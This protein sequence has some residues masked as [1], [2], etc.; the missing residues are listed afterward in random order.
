MKRFI[1][2]G[3]GGLAVLLAAYV[4]LAGPERSAAPPKQPPPSVVQQ[5]QEKSKF[6]RV[7]YISEIQETRKQLNSSGHVITIHHN[8]N[9]TSHYMKH[10]VTVKF[11]TPPSPDNLANTM[12]RINGW[13]K[14]GNGTMYIFKSHTMSTD[15][16]IAYFSKRQDVQFA[17]PNFLLLPNTTPNDTLY[18]RYQWNMPAIDMERAWD[19]SKG[20][21]DVIIAIIDTGV[22]LTHPEFEGKL[23]SG[24]NVLNGSNKPQDDNGHGT[25]V[26]GIIA[27]KTNNQRGIAGIAWNNKIMPVKGIGA[28]GS[29][30]SFDIAQGVIWAADHGAKVINMSVGN[31]HP[32]N[33]LHDAIKY[34]FSKNVVMVAAS[35]NDHTDQPSYP[36]AYPEVLSVAAVDWK[37]K[38]AE[39]SNFGPYIDVAAPGVDIASTYTQSDYASLSGTSM[40]CP[41]VSGLAGLIRSLNSSLSNAEVMKIIREA[42]TDAGPQGWDQNYGYGIMDVPRA[43]ELAGINMQNATPPTR[44]KEEHGRSLL[45]RL[46]QLFKI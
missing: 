10:E 21:P 30:S 27:A 11:K 46:W 8:S 7:N 5:S 31:Y 32:S 13:K 38:Q 20:K 44:P 2:Y 4:L 18:S 9:E 25:H 15:E 22:D 36:A 23:V 12:S 34:A 29:G 24:Y 43:L 42:T 17:E 45:E 35:G 33:V 14:A 6:Y 39:F 26:A 37:G 1:R 3:A 16:L 28:D 19:I 40:A 41:H